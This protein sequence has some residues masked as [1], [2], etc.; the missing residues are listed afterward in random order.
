MKIQFLFLVIILTQFSCKEHKIVPLDLATKILNKYDKHES[1][2]YDIDYKIKYFSQID[3]T[4]KISARVD[5]IRHDKDSIFGGYVWIKSDTIEKYYDTRNTYLIDHRKKS[6]IRYPKEK[7]FFITGN[8]VGEVIKMYFLKPDRLIKGANDSTNSISIDE[9]QLK[10]KEYW[11]LNYE[12]DDDENYTDT[13]KNIWIDKENYFIPKMN[14][15][16]TFKGENQYNQWD[17]SDISYDKVSINDLENRLEM[18]MQDY[19]VEDYKDQTQEDM[20]LLSNGT[21]FPVLSGI[22]HS[23]RAPISVSDYSGKLVLVDFWYMNCFP[24]IKAISHLNDI[25]TK[26]KEEDVMIIGAN[27]FDD[28]EKS[29]R[30][31]PNFLS[32]TPVDYPIMFMDKKRI[33][34]FKVQVFPSFYLID[35]EGKIIHSEIGFN[36]KATN[37]IDSL[38]LANI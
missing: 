30:R 7:H 9:L 23:D 36:E 29:L 38:I 19:S 20:S 33:V 13:W 34:D 12:Y 14:F 22:R 27:P 17:L 18:L 1:L 6:I 24:C 37:K 16:S 25:R 32:Q 3:D 10:G 2:T 35:R 26:Y 8:T 28:N 31:M 11:K 4:T 21:A 15:S 5:L